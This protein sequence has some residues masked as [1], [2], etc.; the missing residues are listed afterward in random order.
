MR[1]DIIKSL[2]V[3][4]QQELPFEVVHRDVQFPSK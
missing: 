4:K 3:L 1:K 2:I